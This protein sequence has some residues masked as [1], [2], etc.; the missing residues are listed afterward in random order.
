MQDDKESF[1]LSYQCRLP[2]N[3]AY[4]IKNIK[5]IFNEV[6]LQKAFE[7]DD[8]NAY[9]LQRSM[10][11]GSYFEEFGIGLLLLPSMAYLLNGKIEAK[12]VS[13]KITKKH[14]K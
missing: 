2:V 12:S 6:S 11:F 3:N 13:D 9:L 8:M 7:N 5:M 1:Y 10:S 4:D 14:S